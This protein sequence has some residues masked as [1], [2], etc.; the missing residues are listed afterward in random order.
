[1]AYFQSIHPSLGAGGNFHV[2]ETPYAIVQIAFAV[3]HKLS[4]S[5]LAA[6]AVQ[7]RVDALTRVEMAID[8]TIAQ[9]SRQGDVIKHKDFA[10]MSVTC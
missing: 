5:R 10:L 1:M 4:N 2:S 6:L 7:V 8:D 9:L 3:A